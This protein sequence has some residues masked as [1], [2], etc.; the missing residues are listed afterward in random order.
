M[1]HVVTESCIRCKYTDCVDVCPVDC[2]REGPNFLTIDPDECIDCAVC[3]PECPVNA[4]LAGGRRAR[5]PAA[6]DQAQRRV[7]SQR[8]AQHHQAQARP[9]PTPTTGRQDRQ[10]VGTEALSPSGR[11]AHL[12][13]KRLAP[14]PTAPP[15]QASPGAVIATRCTGDRRR[16]DGTVPDIPA[17]AAGNRLPCRGQSAAP[18]RPVHRAVPRQ[19]DLRHPRGA[20]VHRAAN[21]SIA[22]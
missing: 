20:G 17:R 2:F 18:R 22:C 14:C 6:H 7:G 9:C 1:T 13:P 15:L 5:R 11:S 3:I 19:A 16:S 4:I 10:V 21:S 12:P 8:L